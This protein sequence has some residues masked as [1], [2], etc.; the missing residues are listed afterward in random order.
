MPRQLDRTRFLEHRVGF[1]LP[2]DKHI[3]TQWVDHIAKEARETKQQEQLDPTLVDFKA[4][5]NGNE[6]LKRLAACMFYEVPDV[7]PFNEDP[8]G[9]PELRSFDEMLGAFNLIMGRA[10]V[11]TDAANKVGLI[12][13]PF[14]AVLDW[15]MATASGYAFF[16]NDTVNKC[17]SAILTK[18]ADFLRAGS[19][20]SV[21]NA[22]GGWFG[23]DGLTALTTKGN[24]NGFSPVTEY[25]FAQLYQCPDPENKV[26]FGFPSWDAFFIRQFNDSVRTVDSPEDDSVIV[27]ACESGPLQYPVSKVQRTDNFMGK[28][29]AYSLANMLDNDPA[30]DSFVGGTVYQAFLSALSYHRWHTPVSGKIVGARVVPG[31]L[32]SE[33]IY[34]GFW[35]DTPDP[36][37]PNN[38]QP[39]IASVAV[40]ALIFI[41][42]DNPDIGLMCFIAI[43][44]AEVS[45]CEITVAEEQHVKKGDELGMFH[46][47]GSTHCLVFQPGVTLEW[48]SLPPPDSKEWKDMPNFPVKSKLATVKSSAPSA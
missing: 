36:A 34:Q 8:T 21:L 1:W 12:G 32:Y 38:S 16:L 7:P 29:Q 2:K 5:V 31:T 9:Q 13:F 44:M 4:K 3:I 10:P 22:P 19:S 41:Q 45:S 39:Y 35:T 26:T 25:G 23:T 28:N 42:A 33:N 30:V 14:N 48:N 15:P 20:V 46:F 17:L 11:W 37:A 27:H 6:V 47:G 18:W 40:R 43:G 24:Q